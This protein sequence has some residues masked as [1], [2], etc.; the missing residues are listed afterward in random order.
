[1]NNNVFIPED[2]LR[3]LYCE[4]KLID[5]EIGKMYGCDYHRVGVLRK[6]YGITT[7]PR[8]S[9]N[10]LNKE[11]LTQEYLI[12]HL[13]DKKI[14]EKY[15]YSECRIWE[16]RRQYDIETIE[17]GEWWP[18]LITK[19]QLEEEYLIKKRRLKDIAKDYNMAEGTLIR[20]KANY[21]IPTLLPSEKYDEIDDNLDKNL[22]PL[23]I[24]YGTILGDGYLN[25]M[26]SAGVRIELKHA[27]RQYDWLKYKYEQLSCLFN[28][29]DI[30]VSHPKGGFANAQDQARTYRV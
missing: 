15:G 11:L 16:L 22:I 24:L 12:N 20:Y 4:E 18:D 3:R 2:E 27:I 23:Q 14:G 8:I 13:T 21:G 19:E 25:K 17:Y 28:M 1:M 29:S 5:R 10:P 26:H 30:K 6:Q 7:I 9:R